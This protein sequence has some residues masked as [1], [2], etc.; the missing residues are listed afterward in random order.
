MKSPEVGLKILD[1]YDRNQG[2]LVVR[3]RSV[4]LPL[5]W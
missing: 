1:G 4:F 3:M 5:E 2:G